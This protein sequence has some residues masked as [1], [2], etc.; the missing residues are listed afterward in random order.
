MSDL[1]FYEVL[2]VSRE[3][4]AD[5]IR[6]A[7]K[8][9]SRENHPDVKPDDK[10]AAEKFKR[11]QEAY[12]VLS[13]ADKREQYDRYGAAFQQAGGPGGR[14]TH[15]A[16]SGGEGPIDLSDLFGGQMGGGGFD[17]G[18]I[19]GG[20]GRRPGG[21]QAQAWPRRGQDSTLLFDVPFY[22]AAEGGRQDLHL[23]H[24]NKTETISIKIPPGVNTGSKIR[25]SGKGQPGQFGGPAGDL[26]LNVRVA[27]HPW[28]RR[29]GDNLL[30]EAPISPAEA[31]L[32]AKI[33]IPTLSDGTITL[34]IPPGT[35]SGTRLRVRGKGIPN[36]Q[37]KERGDMMVD[38]KIL[39]PKELTEET[40]SFY[41]QLAR[42]SPQSPRDGLW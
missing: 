35:S 19:F 40:R 9:L 21:P 23:R 24:D 10:S 16:Q 2:G 26:L 28:F 36:Q 14:Q 41:E 32:G 30:L 42:N 25:L 37:S 7:Y 27:P 11:V 5:E 20:A 31:A 18:N 17:F 12:S 29:D 15:W 6:R 4:S 3:A 13:D 33:E 1:D 38:I 22:T 34:T 8:K 39:V